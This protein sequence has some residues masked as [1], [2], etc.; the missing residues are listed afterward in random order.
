MTIFVLVATHLGGCYAYHEIDV[1]DDCISDCEMIVET[2]NP[3]QI[4]FFSLGECQASCLDGSNQS[5]LFPDCAD[6]FIEE[7]SCRGELILE[8]C[9][10]ECGL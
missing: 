2:C 6:C 8:F 3:D 7:A 9:H 10:I 4:S 1:T 5:V